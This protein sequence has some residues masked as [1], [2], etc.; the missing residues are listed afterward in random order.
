MFCVAVGG[1]MG[2]VLVWFV[3]LEVVEWVQRW[4]SRRCRERLEW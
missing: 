4:R 3:L 2:V 1:T